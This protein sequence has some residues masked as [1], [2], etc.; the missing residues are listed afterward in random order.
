LE[1]TS[2]DWPAGPLLPPATRVPLFPL[3]DV[4]LFPRAIVPLHVF[5]PRYKAM[6]EE[7]LDGPG[8]MVI[9]T[10]VEGHE[11]EMEGAPPC[12]PIAGVGEIGRHDRLEGGRFQIVLV[13]L[14]R[15]RIHEVES[16]RPY[17]L[18]D[19]EPLA[20][21]APSKADDDALRPLLVTALQ[22]P[23]E[24]E[25]AWEEIP[26]GVLADALL[27]RTTLPHARFNALFMELDVAVRARGVLSAQDDAE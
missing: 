2:S 9:G 11:G 20:E 6:V 4:W 5:E 15:A 13:G 18:V 22:S 26:L 23:E 8:R 21:G 25:A 24:P 27:V 17:R 1:P 10:V 19:V 16:D 12:Y 14:S 7:S 3:A